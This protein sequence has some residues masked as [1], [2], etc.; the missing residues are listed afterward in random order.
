MAIAARGTMMG[1]RGGRFHD[2][3][4]RSLGTQRW[5]SRQWICCELNFRDRHRRVWSTGYTELFFCDEVSALAAGHRPCFECRR[6]DAI[7]F[8]VAMQNG[9]ELSQRPKADEMDQRLHAERLDGTRKRLHPLPSMLPDGAMIAQAGCFFAVKKGRLLRWQW[10][11]YS[12]SNE[13]IATDAMMLTP[14]SIL[15]AL[16]A[17]FKPR[18]HASAIAHE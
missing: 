14:P 11:G 4:T 2:A 17:G 12:Y 9:L 10:S 13:T 15:A 6:T 3:K 5:A 16:R 1:N 8:A 18:W 7:A